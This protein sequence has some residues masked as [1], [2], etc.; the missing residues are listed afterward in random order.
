MSI[1]L[2]SP[3]EF[4]KVATRTAR[5]FG[6]D[7]LDDAKARHVAQEVKKPTPARISAADRKS[8][9]L[10]GIL[11]S[12]ISS[13]FENNL[14]QA[15]RPILF[16]SIEEVPRTGDLALALHAVGVGKSIAET[17]L[18]QTMRSI[19]VDIG[20]H[21]HVVRINS[22]G[23]RE[24]VNRYTRELTN[25]FKKRM[26][27]MTPQSRDLM[28]DHVMSALGHLIEKEHDLAFRA[29]SPL[30]HLSDQSRKHFREIVEYLD[31]ASVP[32]EIDSKLIGNH[33][34]YSDALFSIVPTLHTESETPILVRGG[35][36]D[37]FV[38]RLTKQ[39]V[40]ATGAVMILRARKMPARIPKAETLTRSIFVVQLGF[41]PKIRSLMLM[42]DLKRAD[43][44]A[45]QELSSDSLGD[46]LRMAEHL[47]VPYSLIVGQ[48]EYVEG[49]VI[50]RDMKSR[51]QESVR[52]D[53]VVSHM[54]R[55]VRRA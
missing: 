9:N 51:S 34:C 19:L 47:D 26:E 5:H 3:T 36:Y 35:R 14:H 2:P 11:T 30:E 6:F 15:T 55:L 40:P 16:S 45:Y 41:G 52:A 27:E 44:P 54:R 4:I 25:F 1:E 32:Y 18:I 23:D 33:L 24:S 37:E 13:Y 22:Q 50:V 28:K 17:L 46:Q 39:N 12:G 38:K 20:V 31:M 48:K 21:D 8:D 29:P 42:E 10:H 7:S 43:I 49:T 53:S